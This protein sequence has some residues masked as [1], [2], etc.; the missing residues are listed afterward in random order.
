MLRLITLARRR[1]QV[2]LVDVGCRKELGVGGRR[3]RPVT[4]GRGAGAFGRATLNRDSIGPRGPGWVVADSA[5]VRRRGHG[6]A[7]R[8]SVIGPSRL[9]RRAGVPVVGGPRAGPRLG[10][11]RVGQ[12]R[13]GRAAGGERPVRA[14]LVARPGRG[15]R[16]I[17]VRRSGPPLVGVGVAQQ[18]AAGR[19]VASRTGRLVGIHRRLRL[20]LV[21]RRSRPRGRAGTGGRRPGGLA[22]S[23]RRAPGGSRRR[24]LL[25]RDRG[26]GGW[27][28]ARRGRG[29]PTR[30]GGT[31]L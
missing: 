19:L 16:R 14:G 7:G 8:I 24:A 10:R 25:G 1:P 11:L 9:V 29:G 12:G 15:R 6:V 13:P 2:G 31:G 28:V 21:A 17:R 20:R 27:T 26:A 3:P 23:V 5:S 22:A 18:A 4:L 30:G